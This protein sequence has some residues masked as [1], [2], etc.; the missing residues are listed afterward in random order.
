MNLIPVE[1]HGKEVTEL[2]TLYLENRKDMSQKERDLFIR[3]IENVTKK[4]TLV[5]VSGQIN[6]LA[7]VD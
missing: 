3:H 6:P 7:M 5:T 1:N 4:S 2:W